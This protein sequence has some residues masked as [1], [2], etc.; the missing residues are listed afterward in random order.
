MTD[1]NK[2]TQENSPKK[3]SIKSL[4]NDLERNELIEVILEL[5]KI[6]KRNEQFIKMFLQGSNSEHRE[7]IVLEAK[8]KLKLMF[9]GRNGFP[10]D[11]INLKEAREFVLQHSKI[12]KEHPDSIIDLKLY[13]VELGIDI[14]EEYGEMNESFHSS[15]CTMLANC[16]SD[17]FHNDK[18]YPDFANRLN[19][20][21]SNTE[22]VGWGI[23]EFFV[24]NII[25]L[26]CQ[27]GIDEDEENEEAEG[28]ENN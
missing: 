6:S 19:D 17:L 10:R 28:N 1:E 14:I 16:C 25:D 26:E 22:S 8:E 11:N 2:Q 27:L 9:F 12:L 23:H 7:K 15:I 13:Y 3:V 4:I 20:L 21:I 5:T 18:Y 24:E